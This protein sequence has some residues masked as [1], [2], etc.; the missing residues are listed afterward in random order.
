M[1]A[2]AAALRDG[3][4]TKSAD[5]PRDLLLLPK[6]E[7]KNIPQSLP[8]PLFFLSIDSYHNPHDA[9]YTLTTSSEEATSQYAFLNQRQCRGH[10][11]MAPIGA[12]ED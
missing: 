7:D 9:V 3:F 5:L 2:R 11:T 4:R 12:R 8:L 6:P 1:S 10:R